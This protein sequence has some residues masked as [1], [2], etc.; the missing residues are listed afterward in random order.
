MKTAY[1]LAFIPASLFINACNDSESELCRY[2]IQNDL[3]KGSFESAIARLADES[4]QK[5][6]PKNEYLVDLSSAY[7]GKSGL[8]LPVLLRAMIE[9]DGATEKLTFE[10]FVAEITESATTSALSDLDVSRSALDEY[11][12]TSSCKSIEFPTSAQ[13]TVCL[14]TGFIDV[15]KTTMA[16]DALTG[17]NV[18]AW[19]ANQ[20]GD[21]P[22]MLRSSC[23]L[24]YSY[25]HKNDI[26]FSTPYNNCET[27][28]TVDNSEEV[29]FT[30]TNGSEKT[31]N[32][33]TISYQ[34]ESEYFLESTA[35]GSTIFTKNYCEVDFA[36]CNDGG[37]NACYTC[38]LSQDE[39]DLNIKDYLVDALNSGFDSIEAVIKSSGQDDDA[40]IQQSINA[41]KL[42]IKPGGC[43]AVPEGEDCFTM[44]DIINY[45]NKN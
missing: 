36:I 8:T 33:L 20:N 1:L 34:G 6:Y 45:L 39:E 24:K 12:E 44:D 16:I 3:D 42:E 26:D 18:A 21:D 9:D 15:L 11:L 23:G 30:A 29:T 38:P 17:G 10:S 5:T 2:Y 32:Y 28:V 25:E 43:S 37:L 40:E 7:L 19:A 35:L 22:S 41:F 27:G 31:Y 13:E 4:C 14:I